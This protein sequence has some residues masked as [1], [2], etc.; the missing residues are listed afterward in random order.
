MILG[1]GLIGV[2]LRGITI[3]QG[4]FGAFIGPNPSPTETSLGKLAATVAW[5]L[6]FGPIMLAG[7]A[8]LWF[9]LRR[10]GALDWL[11]AWREE[12]FARDCGESPGSKL[13]E[14]SIGAGAEDSHDRLETLSAGEVERL[15][16]RGRRIAVLLGFS[17]G[18]FIAS[19]VYLG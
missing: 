6:F 17:A 3:C 2:G 12:R 9:A 10:L 14:S 13:N 8:A 11:A 18:T 16:K 15:T 5:F 19:L 4:I 7:L 1:V